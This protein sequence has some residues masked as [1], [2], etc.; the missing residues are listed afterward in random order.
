M[1]IEQI[2]EDLILQINKG[3]EKAFSELYNAY[4]TYLNAIA[5]YYLYDKN[6]CSEV[7]NDIFLSIWCKRKVLTFP[8]HAYLTRSVQNGCLNYIRT[9]RSRDSVLEEHKD[10]LLN[11]MEEQIFSTPVPLQH[12]ELKELETE[13]KQAI[14]QLPER[15]KMIFE[16]YYYKGQTP[17]EIA[18]QLNLS[19][20]TVRVQIKNALDR[21]KPMLGHLLLFM[22]FI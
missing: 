18:L 15:C 11:L 3:S 2:N 19:V 16:I 8:V 13:I 9:T 4:Y 5:V 6:V 10:Q 20:N 7:V 1:T 12:V 21:L 22:L 17:D 14:D